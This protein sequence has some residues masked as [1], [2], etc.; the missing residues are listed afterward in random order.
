MN[1]LIVVLKKTFSSL[2]IAYIIIVFVHS[3]VERTL[4]QLSLNLHCILATTSDSLL[5]P[6]SLRRCKDFLF[7]RGFMF[8][9]VKVLKLRQVQYLT[10]FDS[11]IKTFVK[12]FCSGNL[13]LYAV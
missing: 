7:Q 12:T 5:F 9:L 8:T 2:N 13:G 11:E 10:R 6:F 3:S 1:C 4:T